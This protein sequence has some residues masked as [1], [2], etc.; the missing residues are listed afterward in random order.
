MAS[1]ADRLDDMTMIMAHTQ[2][3]GR[4][5]RGNSWE[6][7]P[8]KNLTFTVYHSPTSVAVADQFVISEAVSLAIIDAL[9]VYGVDARVKWPNDIYVDDCKIAGI[10]IEHSVLPDRIEHSRIGVGL[11]INQTEFVSEAPN[12]VS[13]MMIAGNAFDL[14]K[15]ALKVADCVE[16]RLRQLD[17][18]E[19]SKVNIHDEYLD[20]LWRGDGKFYPFRIREN[21][22]FIHGRISEVDPRGPI[23]VEEKETGQKRSYAF[24]EIEF[25]L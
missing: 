20:L 21:G 1:H 14:E 10:L 9:A 2:S 5:Q 25:V 18:S 24:K 7:E 16:K 15:V 22:E 3:A 23:T 12:P 8:G 17:G 4:G 19:G 6:S 13:M 11:N